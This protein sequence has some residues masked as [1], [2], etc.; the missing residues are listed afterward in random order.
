VSAVVQ[1]TLLWLVFLSAVPACGNGPTGPSFDPDADLKVLFVGNSLTFANDL[2]GMVGT[3]SEAA[4]YHW[5]TTMVAGANFALQ[6]HW[7]A[8]IGATIRD[9]EPDV[10]VLQQ[11]PSSLPASRI[12]LI[13]W[14]DTLSGAIR[15]A[16]GTPALLMVWPELARYSVMDAV[17]ESYRAAAEK[18][19]GVFIPAGEAFRRLHDGHPDLEPYGPDGFHPSRMGTLVS[20]L[21]VVRSLSGEPL[22]SLPSSMVPSDPERPT[23]QVSSG[24]L[25]VLRAAVEEAASAFASSNASSRAGVLAPANRPSLLA[26]PTPP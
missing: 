11:G 17:R 6:D 8:G 21:A 16:G 5:S 23:V 12:N 18:V 3:V 14:T 22:P 13:A 19:D 9:L 10:V 15:A 24:D 2:P 7:A 25:Q 20:A 26:N 1:R 4:G